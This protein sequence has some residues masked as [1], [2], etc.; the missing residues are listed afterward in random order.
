MSSKAPS[1]PTIRALLSYF[2]H[3]VIEEDVHGS[4]LIWSL[5]E[6]L[7]RPIRA[8]SVFGHLPDRSEI[9]E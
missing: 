6:S 2:A 5:A 3:L 4:N 9:V 7:T 8:V 1:S